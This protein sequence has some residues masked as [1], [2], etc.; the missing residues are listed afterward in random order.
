[1]PVETAP[2]KKKLYTVKEAAAALNTTPGEVYKQIREGNLRFM[3]L[4]N[5]KI[6]DRELDDFIERN[7]T[8]RKEV[9]R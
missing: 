2:I 4:P 8:T 1:M 5:Y 7:Q 6:S 3:L 9:D